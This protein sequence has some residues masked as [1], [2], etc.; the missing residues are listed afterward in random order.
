MKNKIKTDKSLLL[1]TLALVLFGYIMVI[2]AHANVWIKFG[3]LRFFFEIGK[4]TAFIIV[5][6]WLMNFTRKN[7]DIFKVMK[8]IRLISIIVGL[9]MLVTLLFPEH[10]GAKSWIRLP[11]FTI[12]PV[13]FLKLTLIIFFSYHFGRFYK[14]NV[15]AL[16]ILSLP[17]IVLAISFVFVFILQNDLGSAMILLIISLSVFMAIPEKKYKT[18]KIS[19][20]VFMIVSI[21][22]FYLLGPQISD[23]VYALP[24]DASFKRQLLRIATL[25]DPL[26]DVYNSGYQL[27]NSLVALSEGGLFGQGL[28][29][30]DSKFIIPEP[31]NDAIIAVIAEELGLIGISIVFGLY[32]FIVYR[33][34][35]YAKLSQISIYDRL[36]LIGIASFFMAQFFVNIGGI[37]GLIPMTGV[38]LLFIS[39][40]G[41][42]IIS[43]FLAMGIALGVIKR[44]KK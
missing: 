23:M 16:T 8:K 29:Q 26:R 3:A 21:I 28:G 24:D 5:G 31:Y 34:L 44:Y 20:L 37:V 17:L 33:L 42:S 19:V 18:I 4:I 11:G 27:S 39:S 1:A 36:I 2:S 9:S 15:P 14:S 7:F 10:F 40:G 35:E 41:S 22:L 43:A 12:Q 13:E 30:S 38:T 25:F 32:I 6:I